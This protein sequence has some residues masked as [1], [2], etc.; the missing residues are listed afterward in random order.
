MK[1][2]A[3]AYLLTLLLRRIS[4]GLVK[5]LVDDLLDRVENSYVGNPQ[6]LAIVNLVRQSFDIPDDIG[7][8]ED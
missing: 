1:A 6:V 4:P 7:G 2:R 5:E 3:I 8:D